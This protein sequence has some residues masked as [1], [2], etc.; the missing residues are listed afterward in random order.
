[1]FPILIKITFNDLKTRQA[2]F[3]VYEEGIMMSNLAV[4]KWFKDRSI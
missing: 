3:E 2:S 1:M 4:G